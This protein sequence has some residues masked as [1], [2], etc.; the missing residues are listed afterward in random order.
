MCKYR[1]LTGIAITLAIGVLSHYTCDIVLRYSINKF[2]DFADTCGYYIGNFG[3]RTCILASV[4]LMVGVCITF[5]VI[6]SKSL[7]DIVGIFYYWSDG[8][9]SGFTEPDTPYWTPL[10]ASFVMAFILFPLMLVREVTFLLKL[11]QFGVVSALFLLVF[12]ITKS[13]TSEKGV[14][15]DGSENL[16]SGDASVLCGI[17]MITYLKHNAVIN[18]MTPN[19]VPENNRRD[20]A[21]S[22]IFACLSHLVFLCYL[23]IIR[24]EPR[25]LSAVFLILLTQINF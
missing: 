10:I 12:I 19:R 23:F 4:T 18:M 25:N 14:V 1:I 24:I 17:M 11:S 3:K 2:E 5:V 7:F 21:L 20:L 16:V 8:S 15:I 6:M 22:Y 9:P 13:F